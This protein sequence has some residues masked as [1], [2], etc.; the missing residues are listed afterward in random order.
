MKLKASP[1]DPVQSAKAA[2]LR[3]VND[4][5]PGFTRKAQGERFAYFDLKGKRINDAEVL[6]R[7]KSLAI[8]PAWTDVWFCPDPNGHLQAIAYDARLAR[9]IK[10]CQDLPEQELFEYVDDDG[11]RRDVTSGDVNAYL[12]EI[13][14]QDFTA[15]DFRTWAGTVLAALALQEFKAFDSQAQAKRNVVRA[16]ETVA[17]RLGNT[18]T[19]CR[20]CYVHPALIESYLD[21]TMLDALRQQAEDEIGG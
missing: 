12:K 11:N 7:L 14:G 4:D 18:P 8:P 5:S 16:I 3:Y 13:S 1:P 2:G 10:K 9:I 6:A 19:V 20:K 17:K 21:G 15:K